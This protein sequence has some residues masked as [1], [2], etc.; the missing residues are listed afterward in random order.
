MYKQS[1]ASAFVSLTAFTLKLW[2]EFCN[3]EIPFL[4]LRD[5]GIYEVYQCPHCKNEKRYAVR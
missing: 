4:F 1:P 3:R 2:C 5:E